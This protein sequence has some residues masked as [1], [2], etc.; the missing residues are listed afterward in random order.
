[1]T[2][3]GGDIDHVVGEMRELVVEVLGHHRFDIVDAN[4]RTTGRDFLLKIWELVLS[5]PLGIA[6]IHESMPRKTL[7]NIFYELGLMHA[8]GKET[9]VIKSRAAEIPSDFIRTEYIEFG[10]RAEEKLEQFMLDV[11]ARPEYYGHMADQLENNPLL[12]ID[13]LRRAFLV[14]GDEGYRDR[15]RDYFASAGLA[16]RAKTSVEALLA[17]F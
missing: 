9:L 17:Q 10:S 16:K 8:Y 4:S 7:A 12:S 2:Q 5:V 6:L 11:E 1:M 15:A 13:Y 3:L 14:C